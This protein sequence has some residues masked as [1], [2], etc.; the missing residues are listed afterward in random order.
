MLPDSVRL[1][2]GARAVALVVALLA[3]PLMAEAQQQP[4]A[5]VYRVGILANA[6]ETADGPLFEAFLDGLGKLGYVEDQNII[7]EWRSSEGDAERLPVLAAD[8]V[9]SKVDVIVATSLGPARAAAL[10][11]KTV[12]IVF[13]V[14]ADPVGHGLVN[15]LTRPEANVTGLA[16]YVPRE[17]SERVLQLL[18]EAS[19]NLSRLAVIMNSTNLVHRDVMAQALSPAAQRAGVTL[20]PLDVQSVNDLQ[21]G[22]ETATRERA[23][24]I[25]V[26]GDV[27]TFVHRTRIVMLAAKAKLPAMYSGRGAVQAGGLMSYGPQLRDLFRRAATYVD[28]ILK[29]AKPS[30][31]P[32]EQPTKFE[33]AVNLKTAQALG[34]TIPPSL[35][36][37]A[38]EIVR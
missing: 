5:K 10:A 28:K 17:I 37:R 4:A 33:L 21:R 32:I 36:R 34:L 23:D 35:L 25:Y 38:D 31:L 7:I 19:I 22:F 8:L 20:I 26:L 24:A 12:P 30:D 3:A 15:N 29:G 11:T 16:T 6:L 18:R 9:R 2:V 14:S 27:F 1:R 13:V